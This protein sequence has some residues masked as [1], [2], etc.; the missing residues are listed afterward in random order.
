M[1]FDEVGTMIIHVY[2][3][4]WNQGW[5]VAAFPRHRTVDE[6]VEMTNWCYNAY[7]E[8]GDRWK[9]QLAYGEILF[10]GPE[11][12]TLFLLRWA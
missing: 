2:D 7:G 4:Y 3:E 10:S 8:P 9:N 5:S 1:V 6:L 11:D 12:L